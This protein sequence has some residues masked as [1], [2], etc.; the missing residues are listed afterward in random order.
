MLT[1]IGAPVKKTG[2]E[3][4]NASNNEENNEDTVVVVMVD[5]ETSR[6]T[7]LGGMKN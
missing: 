2:S 1:R 7:L 6:G 4:R 5:H 3:E